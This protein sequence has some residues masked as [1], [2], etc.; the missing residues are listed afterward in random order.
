MAENYDPKVWERKDKLNSRMS[1]L[2]A[3]STVLEGTGNVGDVQ[4]EADRFFSWLT[5][6]QEWSEQTTTACD[7][8]KPESEPAVQS[9]LPTPTLKQKE[10]LDKVAKKL[11]M[12]YEEVQKKSGGDY[13]NNADEAKEL[14]QK[15]K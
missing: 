5:Q 11:N 8:A 3:A 10:W 2:K 9:E 6:D 14:Y 4:A 1:A 15:I 13:P 12:S 7:N